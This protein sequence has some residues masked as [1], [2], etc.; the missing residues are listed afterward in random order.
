MKLEFE[1][2][3]ISALYAFMNDLFTLKEKYRNENIAGSYQLYLHLEDM[4]QKAL[5]EWKSRD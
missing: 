2:M 1:E 4:Y 3:S 5:E